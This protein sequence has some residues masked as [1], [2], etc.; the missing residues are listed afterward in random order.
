MPLRDCDEIGNWVLTATRTRRLNNCESIAIAFWIRSERFSWFFDGISPTRGESNYS[1]GNRETRVSVAFGR[2][3]ELSRFSKYF[4]CFSTTP[5]THL[6]HFEVRPTKRFKT[7]CTKP[8]RSSNNSTVFILRG[9]LLHTSF[10][11][12]SLSTL[13]SLVPLFL[14]NPNGSSSTRLSFVFVSIIHCW[15]PWCVRYSTDC[16]AIITPFWCQSLSVSQNP[17]APATRWASTRRRQP[18][19]S[20]LMNFN[21]DNWFEFDV[22]RFLA[23]GYPSK[24]VCFHRGTR[25]YR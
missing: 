12:S 23:A 10:P 4:F 15:Y 5:W 17:W 11:R 25:V 21:L 6:V 8:L 24:H 19:R 16:A 20:R 3:F 22:E 2:K 14:L 7:S 9:P 1:S 13:A 18:I